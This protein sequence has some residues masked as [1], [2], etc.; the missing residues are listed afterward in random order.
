MILGVDLIGTNLQSG[1]KTFNINLLNQFL[2]KKNSKDVFY[3]FL[4]ENYLKY[5]NLKKI[6]KNIN[7]IIKPNYLSI[8]FIKIIW[9]QIIFPLELKK[10]SIKKVYSPMNY[11]PLICKFLNIQIIL[12]IHSNLP[13][14]Y[15]NKMPGSL[16]KNIFIKS[17]MYLSIIFSDK[18]IVNSHFTKKKF[19]MFLI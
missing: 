5:I 3:I 1:T 10:L 9:M 6:P 7:L 4:C 14:I 15:F 17:F 13:W 11:C 8:D 19:Q 12:N 2:K 16:L 18:L